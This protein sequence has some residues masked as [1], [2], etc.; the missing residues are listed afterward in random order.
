MKL[1]ITIDIRAME[2]PGE[3]V[4][5][6]WDRQDAE[7]ASKLERMMKPEELLV[8]LREVEATLSKLNARDGRLRDGVYGEYSK[9]T[10]ELARAERDCI[11]AVRM[12]L[13][14]YEAFL[15]ENSMKKRG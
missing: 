13:L 10:E 14:K 15:R 11:N 6:D 4:N 1:N 5:P 9:E 2:G 8:E 7:R 12:T 3:Y